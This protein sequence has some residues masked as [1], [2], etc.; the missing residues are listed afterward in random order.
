MEQF[1]PLVLLMQRKGWTGDS[2]LDSE[3]ER[4]SLGELS[5]PSPQIAGEDKQI[6][7]AKNRAQRFGE[8]NRVVRR[9]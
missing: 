5:F 2:V 1:S 3:A 7:S 8:A 4:D 6:A 9:L